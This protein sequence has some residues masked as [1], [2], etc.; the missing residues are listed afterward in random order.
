[1]SSSEIRS[2]QEKLAYESYF[3]VQTKVLVDDAAQ[4]TEEDERD[5]V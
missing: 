4:P 3:D 1:M 5:E 2:N